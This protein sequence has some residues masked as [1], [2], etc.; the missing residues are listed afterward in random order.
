MKPDTKGNTWVGRAFIVAV[1][2]VVGEAYEK[3][4]SLKQNKPF[5][6]SP[7]AISN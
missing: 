3:N 2:H 5:T 6:C 7:D 4:K 1:T